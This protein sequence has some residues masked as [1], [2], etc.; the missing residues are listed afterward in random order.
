MDVNEKLGDEHKN[1]TNLRIKR[2]QLYIM[3]NGVFPCFVLNCVILLAFS[4]PFGSQIG[5]CK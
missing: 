2:K 5:L 3:I 1:V 4:L